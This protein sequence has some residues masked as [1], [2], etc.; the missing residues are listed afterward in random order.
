MWYVCMYLTPRAI[1]H[2]LLLVPDA[3]KSHLT[4]LLPAFLAAVPYSLRLASL[5]LDD[6]YSTHAT[7]RDL[8]KSQPANK[9]V[10]GRGQPGTHDLALGEQCMAALKSINDRG[11]SDEKD[12]RR[13]VDLPVYDKSRFG[14][15]GDRSD[16]VVAVEGPIDVVVFEGWMT[17]FGSL[18][19]EDLARRYDEAKRDPAAYARRHLDY[20]RPTFIEHE[21]EHL[22]FVNDELKQY[23][24]GIW[25]YLDCFVQLKPE[26]MSFVWDWR[27]QVRTRAWSPADFRSR[28]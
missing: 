6:L 16:Q 25:S 14:G 19:D 15:Q 11:S 20:D 26:E 23:E 7:L 18:S 12:K 27:L 24:R 3:G 10:Q 13:R 21:L 9:L 28:H 4:A 22:R 5:S 2:V 1:L 17:G 8:A